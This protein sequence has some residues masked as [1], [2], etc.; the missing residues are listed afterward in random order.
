MIKIQ[1]LSTGHDLEYQ[2][3]DQIGIEGHEGVI[4]RTHNNGT[5]NEY[6][7]SM[8]PSAKLTADQL[9]F[10]ANF[11]KSKNGQPLLK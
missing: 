5:P 10:I 4:G 7:F 8:H 11:M 6:K 2:V 3:G 1:E 9:L